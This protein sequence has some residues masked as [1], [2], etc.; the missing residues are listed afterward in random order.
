MAD[1][2]APAL[3]AEL[4]IA[5]NLIN[6]QIDGLDDMT[7]AT[8]SPETV[9]A[10]STQLSER[11]RRRDLILAVLATLDAVLVA[12]VALDA[13]GYPALPKAVV[14][15]SLFDEL[16]KENTAIEA[17]VGIFEAEPLASKIVATFGEAVLK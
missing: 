6:L 16:Q 4:T 15:G 5:L 10:V 2:P 11:Q 8:M 17:A 13:D 14:L 1:D 12:L 9:Q 7:R 3:R